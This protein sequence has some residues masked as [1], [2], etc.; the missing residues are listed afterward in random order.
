MRKNR[1]KRAALAALL[2]SMSIVTA[3]GS[4]AGGAGTAAGATTAGATATGGSTSAGA[5]DAASADTGANTAGG[6]AAT[7]GAESASGDTTAAGTAA[8]TTAAAATTTAAAASSGAQAAGQAI[9]IPS[10]ATTVIFDST[11]AKIN[12]TGAEFADGILKITQGGDYAVSGTL[13]GHIL[14]ETDKE[15]EVRLYLNGVEIVSDAPYAIASVKGKSLTVT[16]AEGT[17]NTLKVTGTENDVTIPEGTEATEEQKADAA[18]YVKND[19]ILNGTG[20]LTVESAGK[21]F[22]AKDTLTADGGTYAISSADDAVNGKDTVTLNAG[23]FR[24]T[25][26]DTSEGKGITSQGDVFLNGGEMTVEACSEGIEG[27]TVAVNGGFWDITSEDDGIN[28]R[29]KYEGDDEQEKERLSQQN[30]EKVKMV[31]NGGTVIVNSKGDG[32]DSNG[33]IEMNGGE[34]YVSGAADRGNAAVDMNGEA[35]V[36]GGIFLAAGMQGMAEPLSDSSA[37]N[38]VTVYYETQMEAGTEITVTAADGTEC[39]SWTAPKAFNMLQ[40]SAPGLKTGDQIT[41]KAADDE[42]KI[43]L[44]DVNTYEGTAAGGRGGRG[45][46]GGRGG[47]GGQGGFP[48]GQGGFPGDGQ[49]PPEGMMPPEGFDGQNMPEGKESFR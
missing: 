26:T 15:K 23:T 24:V 21:A 36:N 31:F 3:C 39:V 40:V 45:G 10:G 38:I 12:G 27:L 30:N 37:Q 13:N 17:S 5:T 46:F 41:I 34:V 43:T 2:L 6:A 29:E 4:Q 32:L 49:Q 16:L 9:P 14:I 1:K 22:H 47:R 25:I 20:T 19:L 48:G 33:S 11:G 42:K 28:A 8:G 7:G 35:L 44:S 18:V